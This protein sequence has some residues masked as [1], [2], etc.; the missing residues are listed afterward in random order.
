[1]QLQ[2]VLEAFSGIIRFLLLQVGTPKAVIGF[3]IL[4]IVFEGALKEN[5]RLFE[6]PAFV[7]FETE[8]ELIAFVLVRFG[9]ARKWE[10]LGEARRVRLGNALGVG[11]QLLGGDRS[12]VQ[13][14]NVARRVDQKRERDTHIA[15][16]VESSPINE[17]VHANDFRSRGK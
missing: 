13:L 16:A 10:S 1:M 4:R 7:K 14:D 15:M 9:Q 8:G 5:F 3:R 17:V 6:I 2:D 11:G 12:S